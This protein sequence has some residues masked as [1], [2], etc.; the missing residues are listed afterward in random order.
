MTTERQHA[1]TGGDTNRPATAKST[2]Q[3]VVQDT[4]GSADV[5]TAMGGKR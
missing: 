4:H 5:Q 2:M 3:A 1:A